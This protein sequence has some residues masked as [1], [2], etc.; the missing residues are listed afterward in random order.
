[1]WKVKFLVVALLLLVFIHETES[2]RRRRRRRNLPPPCVPRNCQ[3]S[4]WNP[5]SSCSHQCGTSGTQTRTRTITL[6]ASCGGSCP[7]ALS[8]TL[9]CNRDNCQNSGTPI[10]SG[11]SCPPGYNGTCCEIG[12][13]ET[14]HQRKLNTNKRRLILV[15]RRWLIL[16]TAMFR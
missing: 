6:A 12:K 3:V 11:C 8:E 14:N 16:G 13:L 1:M 4:S 15:K 2:W 9:P 10:S 5:W 7:F